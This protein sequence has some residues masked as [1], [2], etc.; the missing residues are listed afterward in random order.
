MFQYL[1]NTYAIKHPSATNHFPAANPMPGPPAT[2]QHL[3][4]QQP[5][6]ANLQEANWLPASQQPIVVSLPEANHCQPIRCQPP[7]S[8]SAANLQ[9][10]RAANHCRPP[11]S[12]SLS[13]NLLP[14]KEANRRPASCQ[15]IIIILPRS[16]QLPASY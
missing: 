1:T 12:K 15:P 9:P 5:I 6:T 3:A 16:N 8:L 13:A 4:F 7:S 14:T 11:R 2:N 10:L